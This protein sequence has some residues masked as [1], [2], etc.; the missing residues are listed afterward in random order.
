MVM[1]S[2]AP[3]IIDLDDRQNQIGDLPDNNKH[4]K[5]NTLHKCDDKISR[6]F[7]RSPHNNNIWSCDSVDAII[8]LEQVD[9]GSHQW[10]IVGCVKTEGLSIK[11]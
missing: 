9:S 10:Y 3:R 6:F 2:F 5:Q 8:K 7:P 1:I 11:H 4:S